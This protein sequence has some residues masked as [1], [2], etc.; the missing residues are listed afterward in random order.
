MKHKL[1]RGLA[2]LTVAAFSLTGLTASASA[3]KTPG[4]LSQAQVASLTG[5]TFRVGVKIGVWEANNNGGPALTNAGAVS[6]M[7]AAQPQIISYGVYDCWTTETC[8]GGNGDPTHTG[9][10]SQSSF[11]SQL[12]TIISDFNPAELW[13]TLPPVSKGS[14][15]GIT[16]ADFCPPTT[17]WGQNLP[18]EKQIVDAIPTSYTGYVMLESSNEAENDCWS[19]WGFTGSGATGVSADLAKMYEATVPALT[20]YAQTAL[21][22]ATIVP[23]A[24][25]GVNGG[26]SRGSTTCTASGGTFGYTCSVDMRWVNEFN[27]QLHNDGAT[28]PTVESVHSYCH[29][30]DFATSPGAA[31]PFEFNDGVCLAF[32]RQWIVS[33]RAAVN[34]IWGSTLGNTLYFDVSE[35]QAGTCTAYSG[36]SANCWGT[37]ADGNGFFSST[38]PG[39]YVTS[40]VNMLAGNGNLQGPNATAYWQAVMFDDASNADPNL[41]SSPPTNPG[42]NYNVVMQSN[43]IWANNKGPEYAAFRAQSCGC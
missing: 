2:L 1:Y 29:S 6:A 12:N 10:L 26:T 38:A 41:T 18:M 25:I 16:G 35:W 27:N 22:N 19:A 8:G 17:N 33:A 21:P 39:N 34:S 3:S 31:N 4:T 24:Y 30:T 32:Q 42:G 5:N 43:S 13:I 40:Y 20:T 37:Q 23:V 28:M 11:T 7:S 14:I 36:T 15:N 9:T